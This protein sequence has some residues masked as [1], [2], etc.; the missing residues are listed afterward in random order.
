MTDPVPGAARRVLGG[1]GQAV[2]SASAYVGPRSVEELRDVLMAAARHK[3]PVAL[4]GAGRSYG[5]AA[6]NEG[7]LVIGTEHLDR[8]LAWDPGTGVMEMEPGVTVEGMWRT[9]LPDG[10][11]PA[12]V[13]G[14][15][16]PTV[17][18]CV[19]MNI[20]GKNHFKVGPFGDHVLE[21]DLLTPRGELLTCSRDANADIFRAVIGGFG[22]LGVTTRVRMQ[23]K[24]VT[25]G[26][27]RVEA[28]STPDLDALFDAFEERLPGSD[29]LVGWIDAFGAG[30]GLGRAI[31]HQ[32]NY[33][34]E[35]EDPD[36]VRSCSL[37]AQELP[38]R[39][40]GVIP[41]GLMWRLLQ[42]FAHQPGMRLVNLGKV[43]FSRL[44][45]RVGKTYLQSH[46]A[47]AFLLDY[48]PRWRDAYGSGGFIQVQPFVPKESARQTMRAILELCQRRGIR[49]YLAVFKKHTADDYLLS[50][51]L[52]GY[53]LAMDFPVTAATR[54]AVWKLGQEITELVVAAG[55]KVYFAKDAVA[56]PD[57]VARAYGTEAIEAFRRLKARLDPD[58]IWSSELSRRVL[59]ELNSGQPVPN[60]AKTGA[61][62]SK[63]AGKS[64]R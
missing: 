58:G 64:S 14:T 23:L 10:W 29:Y 48:V 5:D 41:R 2:V 43:T 51:A 15:M 26:N 57:Q 63:V 60:E 62:P 12:V 30:R 17:G 45:D 19:A 1:Y 28:W 40:F 47:F 27:V 18:G 24:R 20:H 61:T 4:R 8:I 50:H 3:R 49:P 42:P 59:P 36:P 22:M 9:A 39:F 16:H 32:A 6:M 25:S 46:V 56:R 53:S 44:F 33:L 34:A 35:G 13:P 54:D 11:W 7:G 55:G 31:V 38:E 21:L 52:D 37:E